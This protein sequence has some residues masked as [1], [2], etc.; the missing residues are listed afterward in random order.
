ME[1]LFVD[2]GGGEFEVSQT[3]DKIWRFLNKEKAKQERQEREQQLD[4]TKP[5]QTRDGRAVRVLCTDFNPPEKAISGDGFCIVAIV[6][7]PSGG[8]TVETF[9]AKGH[10]LDDALTHELDLANAP[11]PRASWWMNIYETTFGTAFS[12]REAADD[13]IGASNRIGVLEIWREGDEIRTRAHKA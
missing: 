4:L 8:E 7:L 1:I 5:V 2:V 13:A 9:T 11:A 3:R 6:P 10:Y 12:S